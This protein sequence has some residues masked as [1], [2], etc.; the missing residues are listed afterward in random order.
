[1]SVLRPRRRPALLLLAVLALLLLLLSPMCRLIAEKL[2]SKILGRLHR[3]EDH[4][5]AE[6]RS[7]HLPS[8]VFF[9]RL[10][11][12]QIDCPCNIPRHARWGQMP[13]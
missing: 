13:C 5:V 6:E 3:I 2:A 4:C 11:L 7:E 1:M 9:P 10:E 8:E 12:N